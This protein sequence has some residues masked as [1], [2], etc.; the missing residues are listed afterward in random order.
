MNDL[1]YYCT[2]KFLAARM[3]SLVP[4]KAISI[5][6]PS[7]GTG[8]LL[9][10]VE[11]YAKKSEGYRHVSWCEIDEDRKKYINSYK[12]GLEGSDFLSTSFTE[13]FDCVIM[14]PPFNRAEDHF[15]KAYEL[16]K[17]GGKMICLV[18]E[19]T[20]QGKT[21]KESVMKSIIDDE[22]ADLEVI[23][24]AF[25]SK[26]AG[27]SEVTCILIT[28]VK[29]VKDEEDQS[30]YHSNLKDKVKSNDLQLFDSTEKAKIAR[31]DLIKT[32]VDNYERTKDEFDNA[33]TAI[34]KLNSTCPVTFDQLPSLC[35]KKEF[36]DAM[37]AKCW[38]KIFEQ[39]K[40]SDYLTTS[41][42][43]KFHEAQKGQNINEFNVKNIGQL[44]L[45]LMNSV[46]DIVERSTQDLYKKFT[47]YH[48]D[49]ARIIEGWKTNSA[50]EI[51]EKIILPG[52]LEFPYRNE[53]PRYLA[54]DSR[55]FLMDVEKVLC[56]LIGKKHSDISPD[57]NISTV[58]T[59]LGYIN[60]YDFGVWHESY[61]FKIKVFK[62][63]TMHLVF[64]DKKLLDKLNLI[65]SGQA[66]NLSGSF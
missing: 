48:K 4:S 22:G 56:L 61:F 26:D 35:N 47:C 24:G 20:L 27:K 64:K 45:D 3:A 7:A 12:Y 41:E 13:K 66:K 62:K 39:S 50:F 2:P 18:S 10:A 36:I 32:M 59:A 44:L 60:D 1:Q 63:R 8:A 6:E 46:N 49:N 17:D 55:D 38:Q 53:T 57:T 9:S 28:F 5:L 58:Q 34:Y 11:K 31:F 52:M 15:F 30:A 42:R 25:A 29:G 16:L 37:R 43:N 19:A 65:G 14:N 54:Y 23:E 51:N 33:L 21:K 40:I